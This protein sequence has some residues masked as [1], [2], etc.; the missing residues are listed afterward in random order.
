VTTLDDIV[1]VLLHPFPVD[2]TFWAPMWREVDLSVHVMTPDVPGFGS[3]TFV[4]DHVSIVEVADDLAGLIAESGRRAV[5]CG[6]SLGGYIALSLVARHPEVV[7]GLLLAN[8]RAEADSETARRGREQAIDTIRIDGFDVWRNAFIPKLL[9]PH[10]APHTLDVA[11]SLAAAQ[12]PEAVISA[13]LAL[14]DR[15]DRTADLGAIA[16][17]TIVVAGAEDQV[18]PTEAIDL[19][20]SGIPG[21]QKRVISDAGHLTALE[22]PETFAEVLRELVE[23]VLA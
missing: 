8:T 22:Q 12:R 21:A 10:P 4:P 1:V 20:A 5:V 19:L 14:R 23:R 6:L 9:R 15:P 13:L 2:G 3:N 16:V 7:A 17:P 18:T 11:W